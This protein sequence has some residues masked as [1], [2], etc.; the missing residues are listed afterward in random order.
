MVSSTYRKFVTLT[1]RHIVPKLPAPNVHT[2]DTVWP[3]DMKSLFI[4]K[5]FAPL[6]VIKGIRSLNLE[7]AWR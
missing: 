7:L 1:K 2:H 3:N 6:N 4:S 5:A